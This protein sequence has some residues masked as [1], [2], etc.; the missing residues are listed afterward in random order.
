MKLPIN[1]VKVVLRSEFVPVQTVLYQ[2]SQQP[3]VSWATFGIFIQAQTQYW[4]LIIASFFMCICVCSQLRAHAVDMNGNQVENPIDLYI[5][6]ID[7]N[8][9]RPEFQNQV[10][11]G[12]VAEGSKPGKSF[13]SFT[14]C[15]YTASWK[16]TM[17][18]LVHF[19]KWCDLSVWSCR[20]NILSFLLYCH[21]ENDLINK[22]LVST[23]LHHSFL[24]FSSRST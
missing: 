17:K 10:Y 7:M 3:V 19:G 23:K 14:H 13:Y 5:Y 20:L 12:S 1:K 11:N 22:P 16:N 9:N 4:L 24:C 21:N 18:T 15:R 2:S 8:D 6:V